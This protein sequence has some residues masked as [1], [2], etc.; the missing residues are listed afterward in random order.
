VKLT[1]QRSHYTFPVYCLY[2]HLTVHLVTLTKSCTSILLH[3]IASCLLLSLPSSHSTAPFPV[4]LGPFMVFLQNPPCIC[5]KFY[6]MLFTGSQVVPCKNR[7]RQSG[8]HDEANWHISATVPYKHNTKKKTTS[9]SNLFICTTFSGTLRD[10]HYTVWGI[11]WTGMYAEQVTDWFK[12]W[13]VLLPHR[14]VLWFGTPSHILQ[15]EW[16]I[17]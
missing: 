1:A 5:I 3:Y 16:T 12:T 8:K 4:L 9:P 15:G 6:A 13:Q 2:R 11:K 10:L 14:A 7:C 17:P